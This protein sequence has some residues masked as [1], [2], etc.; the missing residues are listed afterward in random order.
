MN[1]HIEVGGVRIASFLHETNRDV[2]FDALVEY[3]GE[4]NEQVFTKEDD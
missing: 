2:C 3:W 4:E 1:H